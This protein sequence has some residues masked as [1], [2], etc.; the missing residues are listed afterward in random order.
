MKSSF[1]V[2]VTVEIVRQYNSVG[3]QL[4]IAT[5][6]L[7]VTAVPSLTCTS[8]HYSQLKTTTWIFM[9]VA[10]DCRDEGVGVRVL[11][12]RLH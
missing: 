8:S 10:G 1:E 6:I 7:R 12:V 2:S 9:R 3:I 4:Y 11:V 5:F